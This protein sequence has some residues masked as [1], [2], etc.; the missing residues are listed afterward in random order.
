MNSESHSVVLIEVEALRQIIRHEL[1]RA[2][3]KAEERSAS[4]EEKPQLLKGVGAICQYCG[5][6]RSKYYNWLR[7]YPPFRRAIQQI[8]RIPRAN[9]RDL[10]AALR[11][12]SKLR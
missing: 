2:L 10:E 8:G 1:D 3:L 11:E 4:Q 12:M 9:T 5:I 6:G 7:D